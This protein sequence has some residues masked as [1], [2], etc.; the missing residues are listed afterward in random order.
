VNASVDL[1]RRRRIWREDNLDDTPGM[2][3]PSASPDLRL[4]LR[5]A[6]AALDPDHAEMFVLRYVEG[7]DNGEIARL[8]GRSKTAIALT[9]FRIRQRLQK[10]L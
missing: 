6:L 9:L 7:L 10:E 5:Q 3:A 1:L 4:R 8:Y 2:T